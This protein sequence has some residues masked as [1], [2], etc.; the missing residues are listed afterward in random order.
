MFLIVDILLIPLKPNQW[1]LLS[2]DIKT[3]NKLLIHIT[4][5]QD[6][7]LLIMVQGEIREEKIS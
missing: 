1:L 3:L 2:E 7:Q 5:L 4:V 6:K